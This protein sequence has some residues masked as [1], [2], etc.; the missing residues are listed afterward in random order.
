MIGICLCGARGRMGRRLVELIGQTPD[1]RLSSALERPGHPELGR[2]VVEG[3]RLVERAEEAMAAAA[4][5]LDFSLATG[6]D[7]RL[8]LAARLGKSY[9]TG[10]TGLAAT[11]KEELRRA[12]E[13]IPVL[14]SSNMSRGVWALGQLLEQA[15]R[16]LP[17][18]DVEIF[19]IH[20]AGKADSPS[21]TAL[22]LAETVKKIRAGECVYG[23][24]SKRRS[25]E[26][27]IASARGGDVVGEHQ[28]L[29]LAPGEELILTHR[30]TS[31]DH[32]CRG[33]L[34][35]VRF[36]ARAAPGLYSMD[37]VFRGA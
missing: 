13:K 7:E 26:V 15:L 32:F 21:G 31:R 12:A 6:L 36:V 2:E 35:A 34:E 18:C 11:Q 33:A 20:H 9:V 19:E 25:T 24:Q 29:L 1:L 23:R 37:D 14:W 17:H 27:G 10:I 4:V 3:V 30:A 16:L 28:L 22:Q 5:V 8:R